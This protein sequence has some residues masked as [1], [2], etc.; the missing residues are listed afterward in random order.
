MIINNGGV[1]SSGRSLTNSRLLS[2]IWPSGRIS[3]K[4]DTFN[5]SFFRCGY[6]KKFCDVS[7]TEHYSTVDDDLKFWRW[8]F[9][10]SCLES[11]S[12]T[13]GFTRGE[14]LLNEFGMDR[15][16]QN[17]RWIGIERSHHQKEN[18]KWHSSSL[19]AENSILEQPGH[20]LLF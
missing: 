16:N 17:R 12:N 19:V 14:P 20:Y 4:F 5:S 18:K 3:L 8:Q 10:S 7:P 13:D 15:A 9:C 11:E 1:I 6:V 2:V